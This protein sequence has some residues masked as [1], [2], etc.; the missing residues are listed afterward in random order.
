M[1]SV[2]RQTIFERILTLIEAHWRH[3]FIS[4]DYLVVPDTLIDL[5]GNLS[6]CY[7]QWPLVTRNIKHSSA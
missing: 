3:N 2:G 5:F 6:T 7:N 4:V 1:V